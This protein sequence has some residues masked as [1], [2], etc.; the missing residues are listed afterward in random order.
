MSFIQNNFLIQNEMGQ[1]LFDRYVKN[2]PVI[3]YH[4]HLSLEEIAKNRRFENPAEVLLGG[5]HYKMRA[6]RALGIDE[7][8]ITG[9]ADPFEKFAAFA[10]AMPYLIGNP[11]YHWTHLELLRYFGIYDLLCLENAKKIWNKCSELLKSEDFRAQAIIEKSN[12]EVI[13]TTDDPT[14]NLFVH[15]KIKPLFPGVKVFPTF[16]ISSALEINKDTFLPYLETL[17]GV[18]SFEELC[19]ALIDKMDF[20]SENGCRTS[21]HCLEFVPFAAGDAEGVLKKR[22]KAGAFQGKMKKFIKPLCCQRLQ[23]NI[24]NAAGSCS[25]I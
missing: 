14:D 4:C 5:D 25:F 23:K 16:C 10:G 21:D 15:R 1:R 22:A 3:D 2:L 18:E 20:F 11:V 7:E 19:G 17:G 12:V 24:K 6:M 9:N 13:C 8:L